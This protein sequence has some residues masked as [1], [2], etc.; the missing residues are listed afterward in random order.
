[1]TIPLKYVVKTPKDRFSWYLSFKNNNGI[2][3]T[4]SLDRVTMVSMCR[5]YG[6]DIFNPFAVISMCQPVN[7]GEDVRIVPMSFLMTGGVGMM[8]LVVLRFKRV[9]Q[10]SDL[11]FPDRFK[12][13]IMGPEFIKA[14]NPAPELSG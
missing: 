9:R 14:D 12:D 7:M 5:K 4:G 8:D 6:Y 11:L 3:G 1:M 2:I 13:L 10:V